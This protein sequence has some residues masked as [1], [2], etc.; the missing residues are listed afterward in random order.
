MNERIRGDETEQ[1]Q[2]YNWSGDKTI[3]SASSQWFTFTDKQV[4]ERKSPTR[5]GGKENKIRSPFKG[6]ETKEGID[7]IPGG[8]NTVIL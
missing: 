4:Q 8:E 2:L 7:F 3:F 5:T 6:V 1:I